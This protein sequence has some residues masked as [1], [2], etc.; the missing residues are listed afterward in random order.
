MLKKTHMLYKNRK[1]I[2]NGMTASINRMKDI[3]TISFQPVVG[4][5]N[6]NT[7]RLSTLYKINRRSVHLYIM[8]LH[9]QKSVLLSNT[10]RSYNVNLIPL[11]RAKD[12]EQNNR[13]ISGLHRKTDFSFSKIAQ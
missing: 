8:F 9:T 10:H 1:W 11:H 12:K 3:L 13:K 2:S 6:Q 7:E 5:L 4:E